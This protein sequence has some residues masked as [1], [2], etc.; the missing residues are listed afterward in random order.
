[1]EL[2][3]EI[4]NDIHWVIDKRFSPIGLGTFLEEVVFLLQDFPDLANVILVEIVIDC[5]INLFPSFCQ[6]LRKFR[7]YICPQAL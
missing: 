7:R 2:A 3:V 1:M 5:P 4:V 6:I